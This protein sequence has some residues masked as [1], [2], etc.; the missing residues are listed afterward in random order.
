MLS[1]SRIV[2]KKLEKGLNGAVIHHTE[3]ACGSIARGD[4]AGIQSYGSKHV[5]MH[6]FCYHLTIPYGSWAETLD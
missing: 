6:C 5:H 4:S 1:R 3:M 2:Y